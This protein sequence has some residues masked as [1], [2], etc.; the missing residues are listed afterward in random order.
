MESQA[1][2][3]PP[4][5]GSSNVWKQ[6]AAAVFGIVLLWLSFRNCDFAKLWE[7]AKNANPIF[8]LLVCISAIISHILRAWRWIFL[9]KPLR[10][11]KV[12]LWNSFCAVIIGYAVNIAIPRG[13][14]VARVISISKSEDLPWMGV[15]PTMFIDRL[16]DIAVLGALLGLTLTQLPKEVVAQSPLLVPGGIAITICSIIGLAALPF[17]SSVMNWILRHPLAK[18]LPEKIRELIEKLSAQFAVGTKSL[19]DLAVYPIIAV[20][21]FAIWFFYWLNFYIIAFAL[22]LNTQMNPMQCLVVFTVGSVGVL[23]PTPGGVGSF[24]FLVSQAMQFTCGLDQN[25]ALAYATVL[26]FMCFIVAVCVPALICW[27]IQQ[28]VLKKKPGSAK[29]EA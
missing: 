29:K 6:L 5:K 20:L 16:L 2:Q 26:H 15:L 1:S 3:K 12:G 22:G 10:E 7:V 24:H 21:T 25:T 23:I 9:L 4:P 19:K 13:G 8:L 28:F 17:I 18:S 11:K 27:L 14:E